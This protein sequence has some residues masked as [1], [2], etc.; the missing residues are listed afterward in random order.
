MWSVVPLAVGSAI[1]EEHH[2]REFFFHTVQDPHPGNDA[3]HLLGWVFY[4]TNKTDPICSPLIMH[5]LIVIN[6]HPR[7]ES[8]KGLSRS[9]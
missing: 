8:N 5:S 6:N 4:I 3:I 1:E 9:A 7:K 2:S